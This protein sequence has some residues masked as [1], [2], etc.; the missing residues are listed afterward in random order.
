[1]APP[2][3]RTALGPLEPQLEIALRQLQDAQAVPRLWAKD[4]TLWSPDPREIS[5]RLGWLDLVTTAPAPDPGLAE[6]L[7]GIRRTGWRDA[8]LLGM[9]GSSLGALAL[10]TSFAQVVKPDQGLRLQVLD[11]THPRWVQRV[12]QAIDPTRCLFIVASKSG[13]TTEVTALFH[14]FWAEVER[15]LGPGTHPGQHFVA[16]TDP[17][18]PLTELAEQRRFRQ[19][20]RS[21]ADVGGRFSVLSRFGTVPAALL[22]IDPER[23]LTRGHQLARQCRPSQPLE[24]NPG[25]VLAAVLA[26]AVRLGRPFLTLLTTPQIADFGLWVEQLIAESTG[27]QGTGIVP[28]TGELP[29]APY[30]QD[31]LFVA[32]SLAGDAPLTEPLAELVRAGQPVL[33]LVLQDPYDLGAEFFRWEF[34]T[35]IVGHL[36]GVQPFDQ[37]DVQSTKTETQRVLER[38]AAVGESA[39][40]EPAVGEP[41]LGES[42][43]GE[44][45][46]G[47][48]P[49]TAAATDL[50]AALREPPTY[51]ALLAYVDASDAF[52]AQVQVL[53]QLLHDR[54]GLI[55]T[56]GYGPR[57]LHSTGQLHKGGPPGGLYVQLLGATSERIAEKHNTPEQPMGFDRLIQAQAAGDL[58]AL[59]AKGRRTLRLD[60]GAQDPAAALAQLIASW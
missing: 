28:V 57:Y 41:A 51:V 17:G 36:L 44:P 16:I 20:L 43:V 31:R 6:L 3:D 14:Y 40:G 8:V 34:A 18:T 4:F 38:F 19:T 21:P 10:R 24:Q 50:K 39:V 35:A 13:T 46:L 5:D 32:L 15:A 56:F 47:E 49:R 54:Y 45:A 27:K 33:E 2:A 26:A 53:R 42:A 25:A 22:G 29:R 11:S 1:M 30:A 9:G 7:V 23:L 55:T 52:A 60:L 58:A 37:P 59:R 12:R 48:D